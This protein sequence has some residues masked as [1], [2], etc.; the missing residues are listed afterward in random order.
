MIDFVVMLYF[1]GYIVGTVISTKYKFN[2]QFFS[3]VIRGIRIELQL[4]WYDG[5]IGHFKKP[6]DS[7]IYIMPY[8]FVVFSFEKKETVFGE[9]QGK[10][11][12]IDPDFDGVVMLGNQLEPLID[13]SFL[14][15][16]QKPTFKA[17]S[18]EFKQIEEEE[19]K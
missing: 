4:L 19:E 8:P 16:K 9:H 13:D 14:D 7:K 17:F 1:L 3:V 18:E 11:M 6:Y 15:T 2:Y 12:K 10:G 5:W